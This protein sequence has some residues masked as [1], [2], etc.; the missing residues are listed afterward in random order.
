MT[1]RPK[2]IKRMMIVIITKMENKAVK[3]LELAK[4]KTH[5]TTKSV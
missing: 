3:K 1:L 2:P 4:N 5:S